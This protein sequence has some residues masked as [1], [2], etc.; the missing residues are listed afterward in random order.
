MR[1]KIDW[2]KILDSVK[3]DVEIGDYYNDSRSKVIDIIKEMQKV[4]RKEKRVGIVINFEFTLGMI[5]MLRFLFDITDS[6]LK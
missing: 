2:K 6:D 1:D 4:K 5:T 3:H